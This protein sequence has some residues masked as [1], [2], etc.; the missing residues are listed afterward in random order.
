MN[1]PTTPNSPQGSRT[2]SRPQSGSSDLRSQAGGVVSTVTDAAQDVAE[3]AKRTA[4]SLASEANEQVKGILNQ[5][6]S[7]GAD[8][9]E[10]V[11]ESA[12]AAAQTLDQTAP[13]LA[14]LVRN[15]A[16]RIEGLSR[17]L[18]GRS[19]ED[20]MRLGSQY[21][22]RNPAV[23]FGAAAALGFLAFRV[24]KSAPQGASGMGERAGSTRGTPSYGSPGYTDLSP[25][26]APPISPRTSPAHGQ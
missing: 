13:Q 7:F 3:Q 10:N 11:A 4:S 26:N 21:A 6:V 19:I 1:T 15:A 5:Q 22:R 14:G 18:R 17:D 20:L 16:E 23:M 25:A 12:R 9:V 2:Q 8:L 24:V